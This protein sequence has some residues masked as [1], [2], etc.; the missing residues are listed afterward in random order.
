MKTPKTK[1]ELLVLQHKNKS[2]IKTHYNMDLDSYLINGE[3]VERCKGNLSYCHYDGVVK[4]IQREVDGG[5]ELVKWVLKSEWKTLPEDS[6]PREYPAEHFSNVYDDDDYDEGDG[7]KKTFYTPEY[8]P[9]ETILQDVSFEVIKVDCAPVTLPPYIHVKFPAS[10]DEFP[11]FQYQFPCCITYTDVYDIVHT[12]I[13]NYVKENHEFFR[14]DNFKSIQTLKV[15]RKILIPDSLQK[16]E[17]VEYYP[18][19]HSKKPKTKTVTY[20]EKWVPVLALVGKY[21][22]KRDHEQI[23][24]IEGNNYQDC[25]GKLENLIKY[26]LSKLDPKNMCIC[27]SCKGT[28]IVVV[29]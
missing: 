25:K 14:M 5:N 21:D 16:P 28:G 24:N 22:N 19:F 13:E 4:T 3:R 1:S 23:N 9:R 12:A 17:T 20:T 10:L 8:S 7:A 18:N 15:E 6:F 29:N 2:Y 27:E 11:E 26:Y